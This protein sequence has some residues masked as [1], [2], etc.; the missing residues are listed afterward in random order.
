MAGR[1]TFCFVLHLLALAIVAPEGIH[2]QIVVGR[3][4]E[5]GSETPVMGAQ[6]RAQT[7]S[8]LRRGSVVSD[9]NGWFQMGVSPGGRLLLTV[10]HIAYVP[11][12]SNQLD[13]AA[14]QTVSL[15]IRLGREAIPIEPLVITGRRVERSRLTGFRERS[16]SSAFGRFVTREE[17]DRRPVTNV[18]DFFR[19]MPSVR[20]T[21]VTRRGSPGGLMTNLILMRGG[22][23]GLCAPPIYLDGVRISQSSSFPIDDLINPLI[24]EGI[25]VYNFS[26]VPLEY[27]TNMNCGAI[28][29]WTRE[30]ERGGKRGWLRHTI[31]GAAVGLILYLIL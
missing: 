8:G 6:I 12:T 16:A 25:E 3:V 14:G 31:G 27:M 18:S 5:A 21:P 4:L 9:S 29:L 24:L 1:I 10:E 23:T 17:I 2:A 15:E 20:V 28:L 22:T 30:G 19:T 13:L 11:Y 26:S 7:R